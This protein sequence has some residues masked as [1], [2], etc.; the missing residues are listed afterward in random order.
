MIERRRHTRTK[1]RAAL[2]GA[3]G[4]IVIYVLD[5][6]PRGLGIAHEAQLP[7]P[8]QICRV[9][10]MSEV[11]PIRLDCAIVRTVAEQ[12]MFHSGLEVIST[13]HQ[14]AARLESIATK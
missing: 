11:G 12:A 10:L 4:R 14:S 5:A 3:I 2:P 7:P 1:F 6:S 13:D 8:G 9:E